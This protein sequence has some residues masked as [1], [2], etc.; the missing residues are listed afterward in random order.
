MTN[1]IFYSLFFI[2]FLNGS[3]GSLRYSQI[4]RAFM[5]IY[6]GMLEASIITIN[7]DGEPMIPYFNKETINYYVDSYLENNIKKYA[8]NYTLN[9]EY[10]DKFTDDFCTENCRKIKLNLHTRI[11]TFFT[12]DKDQSFVI[13]SYEEL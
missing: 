8:K 13:K 7:D 1:C 12:Y 2:V 9:I 4:N 6:K 11:N 5:S 3:F 10:L